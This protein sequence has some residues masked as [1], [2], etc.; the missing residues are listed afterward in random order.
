MNGS[1]RSEQVSSDNE[2]GGHG[3]QQALGTVDLSLFENRDFD[4]GAP[5][6]LE[7]AWILTR[8]AVFE[9]GP[10]GLDGLRRKL[11]RQ[12]G[13]RLGRGGNCRRGVRVTFPWKLEIGDNSWLGEDAWLLNLAPIR[14]G[15]NVVISQR[16]FLCTGNHDWTHP[17]LALTTGPIAVEDGVWIGAA[18]FVGPGVTLGSHCVVTAGSVVTNDLP[19][20]SICTGNPCKPV[21]T[22][23][24]RSR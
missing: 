17:S 15:H 7:L 18:A 12:F 16:A 3:P 14:L 13:A 24:V 8:S 9:H 2:S 21:K 11:L 23:V 5:K 20:Y 4:R 10:V 19:P 1:R 6:A 22:R